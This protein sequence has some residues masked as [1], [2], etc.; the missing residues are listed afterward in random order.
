MDQLRGQLGSRSDNLE[1][2]QGAVSSNFESIWDSSLATME[3]SPD[4]AAD[5]SSSSSSSPREV[6]NTDHEDDSERGKDEY[7]CCTV[8]LKQIVRPELS[9]TEFSASELSALGLSVGEQT[10]GSSAGITLQDPYGILCGM[11][12]K[13]QLATT[14]AMQDYSAL[15]LKTLHI[16]AKG[17]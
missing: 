10:N 12:E 8:T 11:L 14:R 1:A 2:Y 7:R 9:A 5:S 15:A 3:A 17:E 6:A 4:K 13:S 16:L